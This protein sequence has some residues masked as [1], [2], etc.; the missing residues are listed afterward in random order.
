M[1]H[2]SPVPEAV[3]LRVLVRDASTGSVG[4]LTI[5]LRRL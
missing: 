2:L 3:L 4:S 1:E 5:P